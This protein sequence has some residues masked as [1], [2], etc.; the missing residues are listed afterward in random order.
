MTQRFRISPTL[1]VPVCLMAGALLFWCRTPSAVA[2]D[3]GDHRYNKRDGDIGTDIGRDIGT[4]I[5]TVLN[6]VKN[7]ETNEATGQAAAWIFVAANLNVALSLLIRGIVRYAP[8]PAPI[9]DRVKRL[10]QRQKKF[11]LPVHYCLNPLALG[12]VCVHFISASSACH[13]SGLPE[14]GLGLMACITGTGI[15]LKFKLSPRNFRKNIHQIHTHPIPIAL[16][17]AILLIGHAVV[18]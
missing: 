9:Q 1:F 10:N 12:I 8:L 2:D 16:L 7:E 3:D 15:M 14:C 17:L 6:H 5:G 13:G 11:L 18:D 4:D